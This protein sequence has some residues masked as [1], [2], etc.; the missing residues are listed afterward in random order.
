VI[1]VCIAALFFL[2]LWVGSI[3]VI[4]PI[5]QGLWYISQMVVSPAVAILGYINSP[6]GASKV[7]PYQ[8]N[9]RPMDI[10]QIY[11]FTAGM[12]NLLCIVH[13]MYVTYSGKLQP[14]QSGKI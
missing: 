11:T 13:A 10:G 5:E 6:V 12:L 9:G 2:G 1:F 3:G 7:P 4:D 8:V 14:P